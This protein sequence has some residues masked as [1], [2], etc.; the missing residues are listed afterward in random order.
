VLLVEDNALNQELA[1]DLL[2][3]AGLH[4]VV[5]E[6]GRQALEALGSDGDFDGVLMDC[7]MPVMD[8]FEATRAIRADA[9]WARL[10]VL[11]MTANAMAGDRER[12]LA[13]GMND[14][15]S[16][17]IDVDEMFVTMA[18]WIR[19]GVRRPAAVANAAAPLPVSIAPGALPGIDVAGGLRRT[20]NNTPL[21]RRMLDKFASGHADFTQAFT[22]ALDSGDLALATRLAHTLRGTAG[23][24]G[25][26]AV[27]EAATE[28]ELACNQGRPR[29]QQLAAL[30]RVARELT[31]V[32]AGLATVRAPAEA[33]AAAATAS[34][35]PPPAQTRATLLK[36]TGEL[37][38]LLVESDPDALTLGEAL[39]AAAAGSEAQPVMDEV[40]EAVGDYRFD[41]ALEALD[42]W[43]ERA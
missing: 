36:L 35:T 42:R 18:R 33:P 38:E 34:A 20:Q 15:I 17:P 39:R 27:W 7:Q 25:A 31:P 4:V 1:L 11:A 22:A 14:H 12:V 40:M 26:N 5:A 24:I 16:K 37:R 19:P 2:G 32:L 6:H 29:A 21:Y 9:R 30:A 41:E 23:T 43:T 28:L 10:P 3:Q 13:A 8:G